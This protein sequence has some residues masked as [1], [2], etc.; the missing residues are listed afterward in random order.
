MFINDPIYDSKIL[1]LPLNKDSMPLEMLLEYRSS[2]TSILFL[3][4]RQKEENIYIW[5]YGQFSFS[6]VYILCIFSLINPIYF[7]DKKNKKFTISSSD[8]RL[9]PM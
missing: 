4:T 6:L 5:C 7:A 2:F 8:L 9:E 3:R 1:E